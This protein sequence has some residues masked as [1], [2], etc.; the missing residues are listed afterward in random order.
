MN[1]GRLKKAKRDIRQRVLAARD[2][3]PDDERRRRGGEIVAR[4]LDLSEVRAA[5]TVMAFW[6]FGSEV[7]TPPLLT[8]L[9]ER[10]VVVALPRIVDGDLEVRSWA[11]GD[12][13]TE[14]RFGAKEPSAGD[15]LEGVDVVCTPGVAFDRTGHRVGYG[16]GFYDRLF[17][18]MPDAF[19]VAIAFDVQVVDDPVPAASFDLPLDALVTESRTLRWERDA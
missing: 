2:A 5:E 17:S 11:P 4:C 8:T 13:L 6:S 18:R 15:L 7:A 3:F 16:G 9:H 12:P 10:G 14:T 19:R 1:S